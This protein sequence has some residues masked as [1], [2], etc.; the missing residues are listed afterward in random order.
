MS[1]KIIDGTKI[2]KKILDNAKTR[3]KELKDRGIVPNLV[4]IQVGNDPASTIYVKKKHQTCLEIGMSSEIKKLPE[5]ISYEELS[6]IIKSLNYDSKVHGV[7]LQLPLPKHLVEKQV[8]ELIDVRKDVDGFHPYNQGRNLLGKECMPPATP[9][10]IVAL[11]KTVSQNIEGKHAV[12]IGRSNIVGKPLALMLLHEGC[13]VTVCH[14]KTV[15]LAKHTKMADILVSA[16]GKEKLVTAK[17][18]K[19]GAIVVD[20]GTNRTKEGKLVGDVDFEAV[21]KKASW[22]TPVPGGV[23]PMTIASLIENTLKACEEIENSSNARK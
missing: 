4:V 14:S 22:I 5:K 13:T 15:D 8:L 21:K 11:L 10:G 3:V 7:L 6:K 17:M 9:K 20:V 23:G 12:I 16:A 19:K 18:V 1:A 2:A